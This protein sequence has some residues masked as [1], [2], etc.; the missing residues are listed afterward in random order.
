MASTM[1]YDPFQHPTSYEILGVKKGIKATAKEIGKAYNKEKRAVRRI[2]NVKERAARL[3]ALD[4]AKDQLQRPEDRVLVD[5]FVLG[6]D[7]F[8]NLA[9]DFSQKLATV[10]LPTD[11]IIGPLMPKQSYDSLVPKSLKHFLSEF[12]LV[13][14]PE[15]HDDID[16][17]QS[18]LPIAEF[19]L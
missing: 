17:E 12:Q 5:F 18:R 3:E 8:G 19:D 9:T 7:L 11:K 14:D 2:S 16:S 4:R 10:E 1:N 15:W 13:E 6:E